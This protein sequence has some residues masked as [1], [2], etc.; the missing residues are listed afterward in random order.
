M[1]MEIIRWIGCVSLAIL[2]LPS[3]LFGWSVLVRIPFHALS[4]GDEREDRSFS[5]VLPFVSPLIV[6]LA[7][8][9]CP[10]PDIN[11]FWWAAFVID[12]QYILLVFGLIGAM[13]D[14]DHAQ[15]GKETD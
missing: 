14:R 8:L 13:I 12:P 6:L 3:V 1:A 7:I 9:L 2:A 4:R 11:R 5:L 10:V 15:N